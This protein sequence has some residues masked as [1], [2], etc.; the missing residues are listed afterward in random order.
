MDQNLCDIA[1]TN[2]KTHLKENCEEK[3]NKYK[4]CDYASFYESN[5][6]RHLKTNTGEKSKKCTYCDYAFSNASTLRK[7]LVTH[8]GVKSNKCSQCDFYRTQVNLGSDLWIR[9]SVR[10]SVRDLL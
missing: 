9:M 6:K 4:Q 10:P 8:G 2:L 3:T 7:H 5:L 1:S